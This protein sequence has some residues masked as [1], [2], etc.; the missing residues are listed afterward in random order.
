MSYVIFSNTPLDGSQDIQVVA[1]ANG[2]TQQKGPSLCMRT[3]C[4]VH[5]VRK[6]MW[7][8]SLSLPLNLQKVECINVLP[9][10]GIVVGAWPCGALVMVG[11][12]Y[13]LESKS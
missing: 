3:V 13:G 12:L 7:V 10:S 5:A 6:V 8:Q 2:F 4:E 9:N 11:E 1:Y